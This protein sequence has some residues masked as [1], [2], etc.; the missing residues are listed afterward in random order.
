MPEASFK[1]LFEMFERFLDAEKFSSM[2]SPI[3]RLDPRVK[4]LASVAFILSAIA[5]DG[6]SYILLLVCAVLA[7][8]FASRLLK[9]SFLYRSLPFTFFS[10]AVVSPVPF[11]TLGVPAAIIQL[12]FITLTMTFEGIYRALTFIF[13]VWVCIASGL[14]LT[15]TTRFPDIAA[16]LRGLGVPPLISSMLLL[17]YRYALL[18]ADESLKMLQAKELRTIGKESFLE[19]VMGVGRIA[20]CL[21]LRAYERGEE[22][23]YAMSLRGYRGETPHSSKKLELRDYAFIVAVAAFCLVVTSLGWGGPSILALWLPPFRLVLV[24]APL[25]WLVLVLPLFGGFMVA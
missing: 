14:L 16:G 22:V 7:M 13:R 4:I 1:D 17:A 5:V 8:L 23:Y 3:H 15:Y 24:E 10:A 20:G 9:P 21:F 25:R 19:R 2:S 6:F 11:V 12:P 18:F